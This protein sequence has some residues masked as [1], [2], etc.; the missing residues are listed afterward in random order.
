MFSL[1]RKSNTEKTL[2]TEEIKYREGSIYRGNQTQK[3]LCIQRKSNTEKALFT[4]EI[5]YSESSVYRGNQI[6][7]P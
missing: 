1:Q 3:K 5:K 7:S 4:D 2:F 6:L